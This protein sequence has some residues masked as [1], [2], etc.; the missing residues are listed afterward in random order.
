L[1]PGWSV[2]G[3]A[4]R[5]WKVRWPY[6]ASKEHLFAAV[7]MEWQGALKTKLEKSARHR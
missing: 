5:S 6:F 7:F 2:P 3:T 4:Q 1:L